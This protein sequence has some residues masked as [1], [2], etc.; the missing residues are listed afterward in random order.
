MSKAPEKPKAKSKGGAP[1]GN[2]NAVGNNGGQPTTYDPKYCEMVIAL[3]KA[4]KSQEQISAEIDIPRST[5]ASWAQQNV[6]FLAALTRAKEL[7]AAWWEDKGQEALENK[8][9]NAAV[10]K[11][12]V[13][14]RFRDKYTERKE[15]TGADGGS[16]Q[17]ANVT[18]QDIERRIAELTGK[19]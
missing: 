4:G 3:G 11:K 6:E 16:I 5:M 18:E 2:K 14:A 1:L 12:S 15:L 10:W 17:F 9:F 8:D 19:A 13:E 7:E